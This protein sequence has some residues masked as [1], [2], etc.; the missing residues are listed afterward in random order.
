MKTKN[1][2]QKTILK[3]LAIVVSLVLIS[4][5]VNAQAFWRSVIENNSLNEIA[6][7]MV[8]TKAETFSSNSATGTGM[9]ATIAEETETPL[10][11]EN[12]MTNAT[13]FGNEM[14]E[15]KLESEVPMEMEQWIT[16][17]SHFHMNN[18]VLEEE[19]ESPLT[20]ENWMVDDNFGAN[21]TNAT[22]LQVNIEPEKEAPLEMEAWMLGNS[23]WK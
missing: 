9:L 15:I 4:L 6:M 8:N 18:L 13:F 7:V 16:N 1:N 12:W 5:T 2:V 22:L 11:L 14:L 21:E 17:D 23:N 3:S 20:L 10:E 19:T